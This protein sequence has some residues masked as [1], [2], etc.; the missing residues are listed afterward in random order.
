MIKL[1]AP[2]PGYAHLLSQ[3]PLITLCYASF[4]QSVSFTGIVTDAVQGIK[5]CHIIV[6]HSVTCGGSLMDMRN[7]TGD[8]TGITETTGMMFQPNDI[9][10]TWHVRL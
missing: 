2:L 7:L 8:Q 5:I 9:C 6:T 4:Q 10:T 1:D 3:Y